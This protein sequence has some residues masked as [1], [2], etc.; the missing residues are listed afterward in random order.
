MPVLVFLLLLVICPWAGAVE[1][2]KLRV[3]HAPDQTR[4]V[5]DL[6]APTEFEVFA[7]TDPHRV[8][9][10]L[11]QAASREALK[12]PPA[13][14]RRVIDTTSHSRPCIAWL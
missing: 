6:S 13:I 9:V 1:V 4:F 2:T 10:D 8:V 11:P 3:W 7:V 12:L 5:F 14:D